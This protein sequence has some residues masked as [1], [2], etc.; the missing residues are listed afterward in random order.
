MVCSNGPTFIFRTVDSA[1]LDYSRND[2]INIFRTSC[3]VTYKSIYN[4]EHF[5]AVCFF[6]IFPWADISINAERFISIASFYSSEYYI[7][8]RSSNAK[9]RYNEFISSTWCDNSKCWPL[10]QFRFAD[11]KSSTTECWKS[12]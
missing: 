9:S 2:S 8:D 12:K 7:D 3:N 4:C 1:I 6:I 11:N 5:A 10:Q